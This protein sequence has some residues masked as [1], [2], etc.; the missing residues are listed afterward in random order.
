MIGGGQRQQARAVVGAKVGRIAGGAVDHL[1]QPVA[2]HAEPGLQLRGER[3]QAPV[4]APHFG[5]GIRIQHD[6]VIHDRV[7]AEAAIVGNQPART[8]F[9][10]V[11]AGPLPSAA[12]RV[13]LRRQPAPA[14]EQRGGL[15]GAVVVVL[16]NG[17]AQG[18][19]N[20]LQVRADQR[21]QRGHRREVLP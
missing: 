14:D 6:T 5:H 18:R 11:G 4:P 1:V 20:A 13:T 12:A 15:R 3:R 2:R 21:H 10:P 16:G 8:V 7:L 19:R 9:Q 17:V